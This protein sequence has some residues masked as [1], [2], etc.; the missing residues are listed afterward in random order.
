MNSNKKN[1]STLKLA[2][3][4]ISAKQAEAIDRYARRLALEG[5]PHAAGSA[6][7]AKTYASVISDTLTKGQSSVL[8]QYAAGKL[9]ALL[10]TGLKPDTDDTPP[11]EA[12]SIEKLGLHPTCILLAARN[13]LL[14]S[15]L[16][17]VAF[18]YDIDNEGKTTRLVANFR[19]GGASPIVSE[20][21][22]DDV[23]LSS[24]AGLSLGPH[25]EPPY[26]CARSAHED[27]SP[28]PCAL[29][30]TAR[31][32]PLNEPTRIIPMRPVID[33]LPGCCVVELTSHSFQ[34]TRSD[35]F[36]SGA[37]EPDG[38]I[39]I[40]QHDNAGTFA[41][42]YNDY[43][44]STCANSYPEAHAALSLLRDQIHSSKQIEVNIQPHNTLIINN[45][46]TLHC[47]DT[48]TDNRRLLIRLF[49]YSRHAQPIIINN[50]PLIVKG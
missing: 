33:S 48:V 18:A 34:Y 43:R 44:F 38:L 11:D 35:C 40:L 29:I 46:L 12:L 39:P 15:L 10:F 7:R 20:P 14:L 26:Y 49:G 8:D 36:V 28:A 23:E 50:D 4:T 42:R 13:Q 32:N 22:A 17:H 31:W 2:H 5:G 9:P 6:I 16:Q 27:H 21:Y 37:G 24:H 45:T 47:R 25:T 3:I 19:G 41:I 30:L 1:I